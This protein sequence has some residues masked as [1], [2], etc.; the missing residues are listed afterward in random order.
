MREVAAKKLLEMGGSAVAALRKGLS[1]S[2]QE[3]RSRCEAIFPKAIAAEWTCKLDEYLTA[4]GG[5]RPRA[6][7]LL[8]EYGAGIGPDKMDAGA[9]Q[10]F[11]EMIRTNGELLERVAADPTQA[12]AIGQARAK[13]L[14]SASRLGKPPTKV[15]VGDLATVL[16]LDTFHPRAGADT[17]N[18]APLPHLL[19][20]PGMADGFYK[21]STGPAFRHFFVRWVETRSEADEFR[22]YLFVRVTRSDPFPEAVPTLI[23][24][25][26]DAEAS[27]EFVRAPAIEALGLAKGP[28]AAAELAELLP[29]PTPVMGFLNHA[30][31]CQLGDHALAALVLRSSQKLEDFGLATAFSNGLGSGPYN[32]ELPEYGFLTAAARAKA[33]KKWKAEVA[34]KK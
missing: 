30:R 16:F 29:D 20:N 26:R 24:A 3:I 33:V 17:A 25:A 13:D 2:D 4:A 19:A 18:R 10:L 31:R 8:A 5:K 9:L 7:P 11:A 21:K 23:R 32:V 6:L 15:A 28:E 27:A 34:K 14:L 1:S 22:L 12:A